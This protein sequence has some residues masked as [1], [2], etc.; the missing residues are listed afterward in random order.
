MKEPIAENGIKKWY[1]LDNAAKIYP[2]A[3]SKDWMALF[4]VSASLKEKVDPVCLQKVL[5][6]T[7]KRFPG[8]NLRLK[9]GVFWYYLEQIKTPPTLQKDVANPCVRMDLGE[10]HGR[11][12]RVRYHENR[13]ALEVFHVLS[14]GTGGMCFLKTLIAEYLEEKYSVHISRD[15]SILDCSSPP[16]PEELED[17]FIKYSRRHVLSRS[18]AAAYTVH[19]T[20]EDKHYINIV[21][22]ILPADKVHALAKSKNVTITELLV[23]LL[24]M[25]IYKIQQKEKT[26]KKNRQW[27]KI[28]VPV[29]LR[30]FYPTN[31]LRNFSSFVNPGI[32]PH[33][34]QYSFDE[35]LAQVKAYMG[36]TTS[37]KM[38]NAR[39]SANVSSERN[40][41][42]RVVP[43]FIKNQAMKIAFRR[44]GDRTSSTTL[45]NI[46]I[47]S[48]PD[49]MAPYVE[50]FDFMLGPLKFNPVTCACVTY[51]NMMCINFTRSIK[52][53][54]VE[55]NFFTSLVK[56]GIPVK[57]ESNRRY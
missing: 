11:M 37:E 38:I 56:L 27:V 12:Y 31:T 10:N 36:M 5:E 1:K 4:R 14:D 32:D 23:S 57:I 44:V 50:R 21:T 16:S 40:I 8:F 24:I 3:R 17:A 49:E 22:G 7:A 26:A 52:E 48:L 43:L 30:K 45:S 47:I 13:I 6:R 55:H 9:N 54:G 53:P 20:Q 18:E 33:F 39:M 29:N 19:G 34:G 51:N 35:V 42:L 28:C 2:A 25:S 15:S 41:V 46:G